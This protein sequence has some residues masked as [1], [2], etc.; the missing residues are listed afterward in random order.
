MIKKTKIVIVDDN[1]D[2]VKLLTMYINS[3]NDMEVVA[4]ASDGSEAINLV[5]NNKPD[6]LLLDIIMPEKDGISVL[7]DMNKDDQNFK[8]TTIIF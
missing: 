7:E 5:N 6:I 8:P 2:F 3:Q 4:S 1:K